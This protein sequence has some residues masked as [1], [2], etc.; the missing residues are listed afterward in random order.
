VTELN[1]LAQIGGGSYPSQPAPSRV[2]EPNQPMDNQLAAYVSQIFEEHYPGLF[3]HLVLSGSPPPEAD[4]LIQEGFLR[5]FRYL[6]NAGEVDNPRAWLLRV[7]HNLRIDAI[8]K[9]KY[10]CAL[11][12]PELEFLIESMH[13]GEPCA[14]ARMIECER[15]VRLQQAIR[16][17]TPRQY[18][19][20]LLRAEGLK[21]REIAEMFRVSVQTV[22][23]SCAKAM[24][25]LGKLGD[26]S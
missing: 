13:T 8:R 3:R 12:Q 18:Q 17:L 2:A 24:L 14:E 19:Y 20:V 11:G 4:D 1:T 7:L 23:E 25:E 22:S 9:R 21:L 16:R 6:A 10:E 5:L 26:E 15:Q